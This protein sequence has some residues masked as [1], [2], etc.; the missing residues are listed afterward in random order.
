MKAIKQILGVVSLFVVVASFS[1]CSSAQRFQDKSPITLGEVYYQRWIAGVQGGGSGL[2]I[3]IPT[4]DNTVKLDSVYFKGK[5]TK[6]EVRS[7]KKLLYIGRFTSDFNQ[8]RDIIMSN[9]PNAEFNNPIPKPIKK[10]PFE[11]K[12]NECVI[13][14]IQD[15]KTKYFKI[16]NVIKKDLIPYPSAPPNKQ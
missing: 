6:L 5:V 8:R 16:D 1:Q 9:E 14:Y 7:G 10:I 11:L 2:N 15:N 4:S 3:F 13:S 12:D